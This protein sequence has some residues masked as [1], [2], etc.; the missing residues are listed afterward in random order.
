MINRNH[1]SGSGGPF[2]S[3]CCGAGGTGGDFAPGDIAGLFLDLN[4]AEGVTV[5]GSNEVQRWNDQ[6]TSGSDVILDST[7]NHGAPF[8]LTP[9]A[10]GGLPGLVS[11]PTLGSS[12]VAE[13]A[14][15]VFAPGH[16]RTVFVVAR[17]LQADDG[18]VFLSFQ[19][20]GGLSRTFALGLWN[21]GNIGVLYPYSDGITVSQSTPLGPGAYEGETKVYAYRFDGS[22]KIEFSVNG[23]AFADLTGSDYTGEDGIDGFFIGRFI[24]TTFQGCFKGTLGRILGYNS[25]LSDDDAQRVGAFLLDAFGVLGAI[26]ADDISDSGA[27]GRDVIRSATPA[28]ARE[29]LELPDLTDAANSELAHANTVCAFTYPSEC[30]VFGG[31]AKPGT[32]GSKWGANLATGSGGLGNSGKGVVTTGV[33]GGAV[34]LTTGAT[35]SSGSWLIGVVNGLG[36]YG[37]A[38]M[39]DLVGATSKWH[40]EAVLRIDTTPDAETEIGIGWIDPGGGLAPLWFGMR[41]AQSTAN[42]RLFRSGTATGINSTVAIVPGV[43]F[44]LRVWANGDGKIYASVNNETPIELT[45]QAWGQAAAPYVGVTNG[46]TAAAQTITVWP[47]RYRSDGMVA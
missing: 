18:C 12:L 30:E 24:G 33:R 37:A 27:T 43:P 8:V 36:I 38:L 11:D 47:V 23:G 6:G 35:A 21:F 5:N 29:A 25:A 2:P 34:Q 26:T 15:P 19:P 20:S 41:G 22:G 42:F 16:A 32:V 45:G 14:N 39:D 13:T 3:C 17:V 46:S 31:A 1:L 7:T 28:A 44:R 10:I 40:I 9:A 4:P